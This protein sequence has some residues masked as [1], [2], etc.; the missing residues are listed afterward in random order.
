MNEGLNP[1]GWVIMLTS[2]GIATFLCIYCIRK[3][4]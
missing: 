3:F 2:I 4:M 1:E